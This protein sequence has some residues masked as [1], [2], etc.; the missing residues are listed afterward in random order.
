MTG[1]DLIIYIL[2]NNLEDNPVFED[3][4]LLGFMTIPEAAVKLNVGVA[5]VKMWCDMNRIEHFD[6]GGTIY[7]PDDV[8]LFDEK[9]CVVV[10]NVEYYVR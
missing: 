3:G 10:D 2:K 8:I 7:I 5:T 4:R 6:F 9:P 1:R